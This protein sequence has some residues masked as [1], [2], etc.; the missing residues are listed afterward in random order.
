MLLRALPETTKLS[1]AGFGC[2]PDAMIST[3]CPL[4]SGS[5]NGAS[6][7]LMRH[8][9]QE[10]PTS[11]CT[12]YAKSTGVEPAGNSMIWPFGVEHKNFFREKI[13]LPMLDELKGISALL[14][15]L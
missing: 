5:L 8:A 6:L 14:F 12:A 15:L 3:V 2:V 11:V 13:G 7:R 9:T 4:C 10:L 1:Q